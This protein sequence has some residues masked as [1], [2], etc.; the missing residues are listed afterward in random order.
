M[1]THCFVPP[2][3]SRIQHAVRNDELKPK[4]ILH[5]VRDLISSPTK[6]LAVIKF[7]T[8]AIFPDILQRYRL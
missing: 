4:T 7:I 3:F 6:I 5:G 1:K 2:H 8:S